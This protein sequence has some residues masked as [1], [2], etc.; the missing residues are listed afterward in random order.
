MNKMLFAVLI[1]FAPT[2]LYA[3]T[4]YVPSDQPTIQSGINAAEW[5]DIVKVAGG[6]Y[7]EHDI[8]MKSGVFLTSIAG[9]ADYATIDGQGERI[10]WVESVESVSIV[11]FTITGASGDLPPI[12]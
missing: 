6:T 8:E 10:F 3:A 9:Q 7:Y 11:G 1:V 12:M 4:I 5:G 2:F